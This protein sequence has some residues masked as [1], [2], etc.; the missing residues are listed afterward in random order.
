MR[1]SGGEF[2]RAR[3]SEPESLELVI[4]SGC[5]AASRAGGARGGGR[6]GL[7]VGRGR[8]NGVAS[9]AVGG[10]QRAELLRKCGDRKLEKNLKKGEI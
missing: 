1:S 5:A 3:P 4:G 7:A 6:R 8:S 9:H 2:A 10:G